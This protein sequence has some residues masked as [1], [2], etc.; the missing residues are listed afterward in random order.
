MAPRRPQ[1]TAEQLADMERRYR[2]GDTLLTLSFDMGCSPDFVGV[3]LRE[4]GVILRAQ[5]RRPGG[6]AYAPATC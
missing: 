5:G 4:R 6:V 3:L 1:Y 2:A